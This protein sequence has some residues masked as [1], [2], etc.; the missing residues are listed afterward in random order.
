LQHEASLPSLPT[1]DTWRDV[2][3]FEIVKLR[4]WRRRKRKKGEEKGEERRAG[5]KKGERR[6]VGEGSYSF[7]PQKLSLSD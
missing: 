1:R 5:R 6:G 3:R 2:Q 7:I 4:F